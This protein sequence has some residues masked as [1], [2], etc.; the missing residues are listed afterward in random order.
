MFDRI[1]F[2]IEREWHSHKKAIRM[3]IKVKNT[4]YC[5]LLQCMHLR[6]SKCIQF[7]I[8]FWNHQSTNTFVS[9]FI[10]CL[11]NIK[12]T[13]WHT[14]LIEQLN[15][16]KKQVL[17]ISFIFYFTLL[18]QIIAIVMVYLSNCKNSSIP[19]S[20]RQYNLGNFACIIQLNIYCINKLNSITNVIDFE[21]IDYFFIFHWDKYFVTVEITS[22]AR[23]LSDDIIFC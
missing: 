10:F 22:K 6:T 2:D 19:T 16:K 18:L 14:E 17:Q 13:L 4:T 12:R 8:N 15:L 11:F 1:N 5:M 21:L 20:I 23:N 7:L 9:I 3:N